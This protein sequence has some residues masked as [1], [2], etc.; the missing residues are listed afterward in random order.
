M[1]NLS[2]PIFVSCYVLDVILYINVMKLISVGD[3]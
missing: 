3:R 2:G 1:G